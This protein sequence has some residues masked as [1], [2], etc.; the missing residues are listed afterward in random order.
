[1]FITNLKLIALAKEKY[2]RYESK[3]SNTFFDIYVAESVI[4]LPFKQMKLL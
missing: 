1:M 3:L 4:D 2:I